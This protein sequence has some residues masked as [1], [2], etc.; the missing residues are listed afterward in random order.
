M[1][2]ASALLPT[3]RAT[4]RFG[5]GLATVLRPGDLVIFEGPLGAGKTFLIRSIC[6]GLGLPESLSV[7]SP[8]FTLVQEYETT[9]VVAH[10]DLYRLVGSGGRV[11]ELGLEEHREEG[12]VVLVEWG[13]PFAEDLG[14][15]AA[16]IRL[17]LSPRRVTVDGTGARSS[18]LV[19]QLVEGGLVS[20]GS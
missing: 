7:T 13:L 1:S 3:R 18:E 17:E 2:A 12:A 16:I 19:K 9:P 15:D 5:R 4:T 14:G 8:T 6:R 10:A 20:T 11:E